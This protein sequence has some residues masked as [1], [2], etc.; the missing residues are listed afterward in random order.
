MTERECAFHCLKGLAKYV[1]VDDQ[2]NVIP[3]ANQDFAGMP[4]RLA[5][6]VRITGTMT[7]KGIVISRIELPVVH[8]HIGHVMTRGAIRPARWGCSPSR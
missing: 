4:L 8:S 6:P 2:Q 3:I 7:E 5:R 1:V